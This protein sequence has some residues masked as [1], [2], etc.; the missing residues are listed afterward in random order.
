MRPRG[1]WPVRTIW[2]CWRRACAKAC[3][4]EVFGREALELVEGKLAFAVIKNRLKMT[5]IDDMH[6]HMSEDP[7]EEEDTPEDAE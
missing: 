4:Y 1:C 5:H 3:R 6:G 2:T 7:A